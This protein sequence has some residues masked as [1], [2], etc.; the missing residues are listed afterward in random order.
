MNKYQLSAEQL[1]NLMSQYA[2]E[3]SDAVTIRNIKDW[4]NDTVDAMKSMPW[5]ANLSVL[6]LGALNLSGI[7][8]PNQA[9]LKSDSNGAV[10]S[11]EWGM[12]SEVNAISI[13]MRNDKFLQIQQEIQAMI[14]QDKYS[15]IV[16]KMSL[17]EVQHNAGIEQ[18][19]N[20]R[21]GV[22]SKGYVAVIQA[23]DVAGEKSLLLASE[24]TDQGGTVM[25]DKSEGNWQVQPI[26]V[27]KDTNGNETWFVKADNN[28]GEPIIQIMH[29]GGKIKVALVVKDEEGNARLQ[30]IGKQVADNEQLVKGG[31]E[32]DVS[33]NSLAAAT[34]TPDL[35]DVE[36]VVNPEEWVEN[37]GLVYQM[38]DM[39]M[40]G[41]YIEVVDPGVIMEICRGLTYGATR[42]AYEIPDKNGNVKPLPEHVKSYDQF[43]QW[44]NENGGLVDGVAT[45]KNAGQTVNTGKVKLVDGV[46]MNKCRLV[47]HEPI[48][49]EM[50]SF[51][52]GMSLGGGTDYKLEVSSI[53]GENI[54]T[55]HFAPQ[56][57][58]RNQYSIDFVNENLLDQENELALNGIFNLLANTAKNI[59]NRPDSAW[60]PGN[61]VVFNYAPSDGGP[62]VSLGFNAFDPATFQEY[63]NQTNFPEIVKIKK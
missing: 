35:Q 53:N 28:V 49:D 34:A 60:K 39:E 6:A 1:G 13:G 30:Q 45:I 10:I 4:W 37:G 29:D 20:R 15:P 21:G 3:Q 16:E 17:I 63:F 62:V 5:Q 26:I 22:D 58:R 18:A 48:S 52:G 27:Q 14:P 24:Q 55:F 32:V 44:I 54:I 8:Y 61:L 47:I 33:Y 31:D 40:F 41:K 57:L 2:K 46:N 7:N 38:K 59:R 43:V 9:E 11:H 50:K 56:Y 42:A 19:K 25:T 23:T 12:G 36:S 51:S